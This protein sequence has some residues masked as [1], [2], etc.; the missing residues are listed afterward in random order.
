MRTHLVVLLL[1]SLAAAGCMGKGESKDTDCKDNERNLEYAGRVWTICTPKEREFAVDDL[2]NS[3]RDLEDFVTEAL[4]RMA[5]ANESMLLQEWKDYER[6]RNGANQPPRQFE[7]ALEDA[8]MNTTVINGT[9]SEIGKHADAQVLRPIE[10]ARAATEAGLDASASQI[11]H[12]RQLLALW[13]GGSLLVG[14]LL[15]GLAAIGPMTQVKKKAAYWGAFSENKDVQ[16]RQRR[17]G[18]I[19]MLCMAIGILAAS[20]FLFLRV[21]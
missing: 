2:Q 17:L 9:W 13:L 18:L 12:N 10:K 3:S 20:G 11:V 1:A 21:A 4:E 5:G 14:V 16:N 7:R 19:G 15:G 6:A 8:Q